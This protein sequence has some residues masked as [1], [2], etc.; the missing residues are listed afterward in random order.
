MIQPRPIQWC[1]SHAFL[2]CRPLNELEKPSTGDRQVSRPLAVR[3][4]AEILRKHYV[5]I[6]WKA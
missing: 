1:N 2:I 3:I 6:S 4:V 5:W